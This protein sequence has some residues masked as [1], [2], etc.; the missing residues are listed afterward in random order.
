MKPVNKVKELYIDRLTGFP[1]IKRARKRLF[2]VPWQAVKKTSVSHTEL[3]GIL[4]ETHVAK[5]TTYWC[6]AIISLAIY[7]GNVYAPDVG[8]SQWAYQGAFL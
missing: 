5:R 3:L 2:G 8:V 1:H 4:P 7:T 6:Y